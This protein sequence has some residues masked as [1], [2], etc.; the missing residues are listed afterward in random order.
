MLFRSQKFKMALQKV[1]LK[2]AR[3]GSCFIGL[4]VI[5]MALQSY[6]AG[7]RQKTLEEV[8]NGGFSTIQHI[9][10]EANSATNFLKDFSS[11]TLPLIILRNQ[12]IKSTQTKTYKQFLYNH[13]THTPTPSH[14]V[15]LL[16]II[17]T[18]V[19]TNSLPLV[20]DCCNILILLLTLHQ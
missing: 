15:L 8:S 6:K 7:S 2:A 3:H 16:T 12:N 17:L 4:I 5:K 18:L 9:C 1:N 14:T 13:T 11:L 20:K 10:T 19:H